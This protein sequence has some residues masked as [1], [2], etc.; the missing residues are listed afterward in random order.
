MGLQLFQRALRCRIAYP[1]VKGLAEGR[2]GSRFALIQNI[3]C[4]T[5]QCLGPGIAQPGWSCSS[6][7]HFGTILPQV[8][9]TKGLGGQ[10]GCKQN[11][12]SLVGLFDVVSPAQLFTLKGQL[13]AGLLNP[14]VLDIVDLWENS[15][16]SWDIWGCL[17]VLFCFFPS[18][19]T[20][21]S[22][23]LLVTELVG[24]CGSEVLSQ[25]LLIYTSLG[26][27]PHQGSNLQWQHGLKC[28]TALS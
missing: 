15:W 19:A 10:T 8:S 25:L 22:C 18:V 16:K 20:A 12:L 2:A 9:G 1:V 23:A 17:F 11:N 7:G 3:F 14:P 28:Q 5:G 21:A 24:L 4:S 27:S 13:E 6:S 26:L